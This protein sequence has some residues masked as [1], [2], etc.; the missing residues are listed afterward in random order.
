MVGRG[1]R[2]LQEAAQAVSTGDFSNITGQI[3]YNKVRDSYIDPDLLWPQLCT[4]QSTEFL[5]GERIPGVGRI[6]DQGCHT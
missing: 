5:N 1:Q 4:T 2:A 3:I 6:G